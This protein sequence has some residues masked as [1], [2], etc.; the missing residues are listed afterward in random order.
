MMAPASFGATIRRSSMSIKRTVPAE[1]EVEAAAAAVLAELEL[2][3]VV[4]VSSAAA[5]EVEVP[6]SFLKRLEIISSGEEDDASGDSVESR[7]V[8]ACAAAST[9]SAP[10]APSE[11]L[12]FSLLRFMFVHISPAGPRTAGSGCRDSGQTPSVRRP[13]IV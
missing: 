1:V 8:I 13:S 12:T 7:A 3:A 10:S 9:P 6:V 5:A 4:A 2:V 11:L